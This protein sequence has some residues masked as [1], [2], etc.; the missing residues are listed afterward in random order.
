MKQKIKIHRMPLARVFPSTHPRAGE[1]TDFDPKIR[2]ALWKQATNE[3][4][5]KCQD[6]GIECKPCPS[7][8]WDEITWAKP[9]TCR[10]NYELWK[11]RI[12]EVAA[13]NAVLV[14][15]GWSDKP[16]R[17]RCTNLFVFGASAVKDFINELMRSDRYNRALPVIDS[18]IGA[19]KALF[20]HELNCVSVGNVE[21]NGVNTFEYSTI[22]Q[23][24]GLSE[25]DFRA[26]FKGYDTS[27][28]LAI[29]HFTNLRY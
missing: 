8:H 19:Q 7:L 10:A 29:I 9:H 4:C 27:K 18:G 6:V 16:Y 20:I 1:P 12:D 23:N 22:A 24:D 11:K 15:Y 13:G 2:Y 17:S 14:L 25:D 28:P 5:K 26:W 21:Q 3:I